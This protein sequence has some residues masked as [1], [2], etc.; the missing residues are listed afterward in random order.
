MMPVAWATVT[1]GRASGRLAR[2][3]AFRMGWV[4]AQEDRRR[5]SNRKPLAPNLNFNKTDLKRCGHPG[6]DCGTATVSGRG[7]PVVVASWQRQ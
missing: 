6:P 2:P 4:R 7:V 5:D 3:P 1:A